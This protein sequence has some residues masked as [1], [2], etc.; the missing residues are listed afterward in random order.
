M[1]R[2]DGRHSGCKIFKFHWRS[3]M[4]C[5][6]N[7]LVFAGCFFPLILLWKAMTYPPCLFQIVCW[8]NVAA[9]CVWQLQTNTVYH[10][11]NPRRLH[12][13]ETHRNGDLMIGTK[14]GTSFL[15]NETKRFETRGT[16]FLFSIWEVILNLK[17]LQ[18]RF[19]R[20]AEPEI[21]S[22]LSYTFFF[23][24]A[25]ITHNATWPLSV[26]VGI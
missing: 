3:P 13:T 25:Y 17:I 15:K 26:Q 20:V 6:M 23:L 24:G 16:T 19:K 21:S 5:S 9:C 22:S 4:K 12:G 14:W 11:R 7:L 18:T 2:R 1:A 10:V 8:C